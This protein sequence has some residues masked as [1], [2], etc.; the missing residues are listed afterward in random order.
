LIGARKEHRPP[1]NNK[2]LGSLDAAE[3]LAMTDQL[4]TTTPVPLANAQTGERILHID[5]SPM[6]PSNPWDGERRAVELKQLSDDCLVLEPNR[7]A[8]VWSRF[9]ILAASAGPIAGLVYMLAEEWRGNADWALILIIVIGLVLLFA[10][11]LLGISAP[12]GF[13]RWVRFDRRGGRLTISRRPLGFRGSLQIIRSRPLT[14]VVCVQL[15]YGGFHSESAEIGEPGTPGSVVHETYNSYQMNL[16]F[17]DRDEPRYN[18][19]THSDWKWIREAGQ[20]L[21]GFLGIP[22]VDHLDHGK[23]A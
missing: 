18:L 20:K 12:G 7:R 17:D 1:T 10:I 2:G 13:K 23:L 22:V 11:L 8:F 21:G 19:A 6:P 14:D 4:P 16:V 3:D 5:N 15:L 9:L